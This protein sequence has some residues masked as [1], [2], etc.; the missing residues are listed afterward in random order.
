MSSFY[1][2]TDNALNVCMR[3]SMHDRPREPTVCQYQHKPI[4]LACDMYRYIRQ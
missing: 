2:F 4:C 3:Q 1:I